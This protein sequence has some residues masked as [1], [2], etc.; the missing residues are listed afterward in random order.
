MPGKFFEK[1]SQQTLKEPTEYVVEYIVIKSLGVTVSGYCPDENVR[2][3]SLSSQKFMGLQVVVVYMFDTDF[4]SEMIILTVSIT[5]NNAFDTRD[6]LALELCKYT[7]WVATNASHQG[8]DG[9][10]QTSSIKKPIINNW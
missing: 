8:A 10:S 2:T 9:Y 6:C 1:N 3:S 4:M 7:M 5:Q